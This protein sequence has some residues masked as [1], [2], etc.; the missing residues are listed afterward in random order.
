MWGIFS[1]ILCYAQSDIMP[2]GIVIFLPLAKV[3]LYSP[4]NCPK[5]NITRRQPNI[6]AKQYNSPKANITEKTLVLSNKSFFGSPSWTRTNN[7]RLP[8]AK[9][10]VTVFGDGCGSRNNL[11]VSHFALFRPLPLCAPPFLVHRTRSGTDYRLRVVQ[12]A[13]IKTVNSNN[14]RFSSI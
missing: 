7:I 5:G 2:C 6:T 10:T 14:A 12:S 11:L 9:L 13:N 4:L 3:I 1:D 8:S